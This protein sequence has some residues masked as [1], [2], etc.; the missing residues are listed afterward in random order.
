[1][2]ST[3]LVAML[4]TQLKSGCMQPGCS[5]EYCVTS[6]REPMEQ[7]Q[8]VSLATR[9]SE[10]GARY[11]C[12]VF[13]R[14]VALAAMEQDMNQAASSPPST[15]Q[16]QEVETETE[17]DV[18]TT[19]I[20]AD[21]RDSQ[22]SDAEPEVTQKSE[23]LDV[24]ADAV[25]EQQ[26]DV[27]Q[28][29]AGVAVEESEDGDVELSCSFM[30]QFMEHMLEGDTTEIASL[31]FVAF[32]SAPALETM[33]QFDKP[34]PAILNGNQNVLAINVEAAIKFYVLLEECEMEMYEEALSN[35]ISLLNGNTRK[36]GEPSDALIAIL[37][38]LVTCPVLYSGNEDGEWDSLLLWAS[39]AS[40]I[41]PV[42]LEAIGRAYSVVATEYFERA[43]RTVN[44]SL[45]VYILSMD[46]GKR[47]HIDAVTRAHVEMLRLL[48]AANCMRSTPS[49]TALGMP[50]AQLSATSSVQPE[51]SSSLGTFHES[52]LLGQDMISVLGNAQSEAE[53][54]VAFDYFVNDAISTSVDAIEEY[55][56]FVQTRPGLISFIARAPFVLDVAA[57]SKV[58]AI[59]HMIEQQ[60]MARQNFFRRY[61]V[62]QVH[63]ETILRDALRQISHAEFTDP[64][65]LKKELKVKF[66]GEEGVDEGG[67]QKEFFQLAIRNLFDEDYGIF[68]YRP[69]TRQHWFNINTLELPDEYKLLGILLGVAIHSNLILD[70]HFPLAIYQKLRGET[71]GFDA[72][73][74]VDPE[75][76]S[77]L[78]K[79]LEYDEDNVEDVFCLTFVATYQA[80]GEVREVELKPGGSDI[81]VTKANKQEY[82]ELYVD[83][84]LNKSIEIPFNAFR[85][86]FSSVV[87]NS[88]ILSLFRTEELHELICGSSQLNLEDMQENA[89]YAG[90]YNDD[91]NVVRWFWDIVK[92]FNEEQ[93]KQ[94]LAF[95][96]GC[97]RAPVG[98][99]ANLKFVIYKHGGDS[100]LLP[101]AHTCFNTIMIPEYTSKEKLQRLLLLAITH[102]EGFGML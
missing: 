49:T 66:V 54:K 17:T 82:V 34:R 85:D 53:P 72:L 70:L 79:L 88:R 20:P 73:E 101:T 36:A 13:A 57:K 5:N 39:I 64:D 33:F 24:E 99:L 83:W 86:G 98:G 44:E 59:E 65:S 94:L 51:R 100:D 25:D 62:L 35:A 52:G 60:H 9:L 87:G 43:I 40:K 77:S 15:E 22:Q 76:H 2:E 46:L 84:L 41:T 56:G 47:V 10:S 28:G 14:G 4:V 63:R 80:F 1:M 21:D 19:A 58:L 97:D 91:S 16:G 102:S 89:K 29:E 26:D 55:R 71:V 93:K 7:E 95:V 81:D 38:V 96:T 6:G 12:P 61:L 75:V 27:D 67:V 78:T 3:K 23:K 11:L 8:A 18:T 32:S 30:N 68:M 48:F 37:A 50:L 31:V 92:T 45:T 69:T 90:G 42:Q 74:E